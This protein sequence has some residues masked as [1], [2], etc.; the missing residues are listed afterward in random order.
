MSSLQICFTEAI[1]S[2]IEIETITLV[3][4][5]GKRTYKVNG[6]T[7]GLLPITLLIPK[8]N[9]PILLQVAKQKGIRLPSETTDHP[10]QV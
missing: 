1:L 8:V 3:N 5:K 4:Y 2:S 7:P 9:L 10:R 6:Y